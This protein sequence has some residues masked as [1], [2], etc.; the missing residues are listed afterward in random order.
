MKTKVLF[1]PIS[2]REPESSEPPA[3]ASRAPTGES[4]EVYC[5]RTGQAAVY[6]RLPVVRIADY[7]GD[8]GEP[9]S[10][11][12]LRSSLYAVERS[13]KGGPDPTDRQIRVERRFNDLYEIAHDRQSAAHALAEELKALVGAFRALEQ[14]AVRRVEAELAAV[15]EAAQRVREF[16]RVQRRCGARERSSRGTSTRTRGSRRITRGSARSGDSSGGGSEPP[17]HSRADAASTEV[18]A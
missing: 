2:S 4:W 17:G 14:E 3:E 7:V 12:E 5:A 16:E 13:D 10:V 15:V 1:P 11:D 6:P 8:G 18:A 9:V